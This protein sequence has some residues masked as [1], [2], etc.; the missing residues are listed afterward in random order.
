MGHA[1]SEQCVIGKHRVCPMP[2][3]CAC[4]CHRA[5]LLGETAIESENR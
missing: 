1:R 4:R 5:Q 3:T 2:S